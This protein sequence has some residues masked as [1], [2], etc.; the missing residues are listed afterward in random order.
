MLQISTHLEL[1]YIWHHLLSII[2][3]LKSKTKIK[4]KKIRKKIFEMSDN[5]FK[6][7]LFLNHQACHSQVFKSGDEK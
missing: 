6:Q 2:S 5:D 3:Q 4:N 1:F 7:L